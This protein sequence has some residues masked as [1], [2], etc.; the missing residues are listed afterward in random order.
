M[1]L[2]EDISVGNILPSHN[3]I[4]TNDSKEN[5]KLRDVINYQLITDALKLSQVESIEQNKRPET[6]EE[7]YKEYEELRRYLPF[8]HDHLISGGLFRWGIQ[9]ENYKLILVNS[10]E[11]ILVFW[12]EE[13]SSW[14]N[15]GRSND[16]DKLKKSAN[17]LRRYLIELNSMS[18]VVYVV[19]HT[20]FHPVP[21]AKKT[22]QNHTPLEYQFDTPFTITFVFSNWSTRFKSHRFREIC[23]QLI[24]SLVPA[25]IKTQIYWM[26]IPQMTLF[27][28]SYNKWRIGL[29][30]DYPITDLI[31][32]Q[33]GIYDIFWKMED[34]IQNPKRDDNN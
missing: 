19:E 18:E 2:N 7:K 5:E 3:L 27:E 21:E 11:F 34:E 10:S 16:K 30:S 32:L 33:Q 13:D 20:F 29:S 14:M 17:T 23:C 26:N 6:D 1:N 28:N 12:N 31:A 22:P 8:F 4:L 24:E 25:H 9:L 15:L